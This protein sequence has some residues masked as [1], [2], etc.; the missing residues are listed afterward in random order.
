MSK[1]ER[2]NRLLELLACDGHVSVEDAAGQLDVSPATVRR[3]L[4]SLTAQQLLTRTHGGAGSGPGTITVV[5]NALNIANELTVRGHIK[6]VVLGC[7]NRGHPGLSR[8]LNC[9]RELLA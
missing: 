9:L 6:L 1:Y 2:L 7:R 3:D 8:C 4:D 5:T